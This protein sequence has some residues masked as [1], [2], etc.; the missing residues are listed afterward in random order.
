MEKSVIK[1]VK[2]L[3]SEETFK[4][5][6]NELHT[7]EEWEMVLAEIWN[8]IIDEQERNEGEENE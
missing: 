4:T 1:Q 2:E 5:L 8:E 3:V 6:K 7:Y